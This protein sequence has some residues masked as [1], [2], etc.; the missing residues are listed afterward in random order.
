MKTEPLVQ[1]MTDTVRNAFLKEGG[2]RH[3]KS[4][5]LIGGFA[6]GEG[7]YEITNGRLI[8]YNDI[9]FLVIVPRKSPLALFSISRI[10]NRINDGRFPFQVDLVVESIQELRQPN[11][12]IQNY[13][14]QNAH[15]HIWGESFFKNETYYRLPMESVSPADALQLLL[16]RQASLMIGFAELN[17]AKRKDIRYLQVQLSKSLCAMLAALTISEGC[18][19]IRAKDQMKWLHSQLKNHEEGGLWEIF[20]DKELLS[21]LEANEVF[22]HTPDRNHF[23]PFWTTINY[24]AKQYHAFLFAYMKW[25]YKLSPE[26]EWKKTLDAFR[27]AQPMQWDLVSL[28]WWASWFRRQEACL[29]IRWPSHAPHPQISVYLDHLSWLHGYVFGSRGDKSKQLQELENLISLWKAS[30]YGCHLR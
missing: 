9:D 15:K 5:Y 1:Q 17:K 20:Q 7:T 24:I 28:S 21:L 18:Y 8:I 30:G 12:T 22:R 4:L 26:S 11:P 3:A 25:H 23:E 27:L 19:Q 10:Q 29:T 14:I 16:N 6:R 13:D 2:W